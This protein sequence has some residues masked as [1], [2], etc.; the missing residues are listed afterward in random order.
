MKA[1]GEVSKAPECA[2]V[3][4]YLCDLCIVGC[5]GSKQA[6]GLSILGLTHQTEQSA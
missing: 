6:R 4:Q 5:L 3:N 1:N 2:T